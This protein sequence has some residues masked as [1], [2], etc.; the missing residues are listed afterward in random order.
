MSLGVLGVGYLGV[1]ALIALGFAITLRRL[2]ASD[3]VLLV[4]LWPV[5]APMTGEPLTT[6]VNS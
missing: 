3:G 4:A 5:W 1:G 6:E 2:A